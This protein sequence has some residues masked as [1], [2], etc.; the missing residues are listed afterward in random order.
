M[1][2]PLDNINPG[3]YLDDIKPPTNKESKMNVEIKAGQTVRVMP[4]GSDCVTVPYEVTVL[5]VGPDDKALVEN[6]TGRG[7]VPL[8]RLAA[9]TDQRPHGWL[10]EWDGGWTTVDTEQ[11]AQAYVED[12]VEAGDWT[13]DD[14]LVRPNAEPDS[15]N[16]IA[17][18]EQFGHGDD[19]VWV[20][21]LRQGERDIDITVK[22]PQPSDAEPFDEAEIVKLAKM[23]PPAPEWDEDKLAFIQFNAA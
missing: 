6:E 20:V 18:C 17:M 1:H 22:G 8:H 7:R 19:P 13:G 11:S 10:I 9:T 4:D 16:A 2:L 3:W 14:F 23:A 21:S 15:L 5:A 12:R